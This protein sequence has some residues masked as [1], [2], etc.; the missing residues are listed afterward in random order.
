MQSR[1]TMS[2]S[3]PATQ[4]ACPW[5]TSEQAVNSPSPR[6]KWDVVVSV[7]LLTYIDCQGPH[8]LCISF[9]TPMGGS[10]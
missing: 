7:G 6:S 10:T 4:T 2:P 8:S 5:S 1:M 9:Q 3:L